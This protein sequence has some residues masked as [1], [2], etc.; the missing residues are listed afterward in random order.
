M[1]GREGRRRREKE[2]EGGRRREKEGEG[3]RRREKEGERGGK[4]EKE[5]ERGRKREK[6]RVRTRAQ[7]TPVEKE[8]NRTAPRT[9]RVELALSSNLEKAE[10]LETRE[11]S[12]KDQGECR[13]G[14]RRPRRHK[15]SIS[16]GVRIRNKRIPKQISQ[17]SSKN[18][19]QFQRTKERQPNPRGNTG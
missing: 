9:N 7:I 14:E 2:G 3:G 13:V 8:K 1:K 11:A 18:S 4:R 16:I 15:A 5:G 19:T 12:G 6:D 17:T 10:S